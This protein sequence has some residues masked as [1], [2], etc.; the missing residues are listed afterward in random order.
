[1]TDRPREASRD[2]AAIDVAG[3]VER[4]MGDHGLFARVLER[5]GCDYLRAAA[6][7]RAALAAGDSALAQR[8]VHTLKGAAGMIE[9]RALQREALALEQALGGGGGDCAPRLD[10]LDAELD[11]V[12]RELDAMLA[13]PPARPVRPA[14]AALGPME[15]RTRL[16]ALLDAGD[17]AAV[18]LVEEA[19]AALAA[20]L[21]EE[22]YGAVAAA[23][24]AFDFERALALLE[25]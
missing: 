9:A 15:A 19:G 1:M 11:R 25:S 5:F 16:A 22:R 17:G 23:V 12:L 13:A 3:G 6:A 24:N 8:L 18:D 4:V 21:G 10:R 20:A 2:D 14:S 7:I